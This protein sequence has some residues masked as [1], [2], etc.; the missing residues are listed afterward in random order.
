MN[1]L[2]LTERDL[3]NRTARMTARKVQVHYGQNHALKDVDVDILDKTVTAFIGP[4]G[5]GKSTFLRCLNRMNDT[6][7][8]CRVEGQITLE[9]EDIYD[10]RVDPVQLRAKVGMVF[11]KPNPFPKSIYDNVAY[12]PRIH[13]LARNRAELDEVVEKSLRRAALWAEVKDRLHAPGTGLSG[14]QQQRLCIARAVATEP[15]VLLMDEPCS[16]LDPIATAQVEELIDELRENFSV[17]IVTHSMQQAARVSQKTAFFH[18]GHL[19][20][21]G[22]TAQIFTN[23]RDPRTES[24]I[25]GRIG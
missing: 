3:D 4:S 21:H 24:Y 16:A 6:I 11:Q 8:A 13:G 5:C 2:R 9:G 17:V 18:M 1:D 22:D 7:A 12:G 25:T 23:P 20:E 10:R 15:E 19:V 14:G